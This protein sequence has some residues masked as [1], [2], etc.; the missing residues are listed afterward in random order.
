MGWGVGAHRG[1]VGRTGLHSV[2]VHQV[3]DVTDVPQDDLHGVPPELDVQGVDGGTTV[4]EE[5]GHP[6]KPVVRDLGEVGLVGERGQ[7]WDVHLRVRVTWRRQTVC[8]RP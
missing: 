2:H 4:A 7:D 1:D 8:C 3:V 6:G 5:V